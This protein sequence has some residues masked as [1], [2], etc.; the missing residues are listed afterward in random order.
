MV[1]L[2]SRRAQRT[3]PAANKDIFKD[4][5]D[6]PVFDQSNAYVIDSWAEFGFGIF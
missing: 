1:K 4:L 6:S 5:M 2:A 3:G